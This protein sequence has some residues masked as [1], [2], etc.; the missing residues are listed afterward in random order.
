MNIEIIPATAVWSECYKAGKA[1]NPTGIVIH[2]TGA[3]NEYLRRYCK[4]EQALGKNKYNNFWGTGSVS[5]Q[6][7]RG[8]PHAAVGLDKNGSVAIAQVLPFDMRCWGCGSGAKGSYNTSHIQLEICEDGLNNKDYFSK[9]FDKA[10]QFCAYLM[11]KYPAIKISSIVSHKEAH[12]KGYASNHGDP[13]HWLAEFGLDMDWFRKCVGKYTAPDKIYR[14]QT[15]AFYDR[16]N[17]EKYLEKL[18]KA[19]FN[20]FIT[21]SGK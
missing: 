12:A 9:A 20:G 15:G 11:E 8:I 18:K 3:D 14:V 13:D 19:G 10:A 21:E 7:N 4:N 2:S 5:E 16:N 6:E 17:A 1:L